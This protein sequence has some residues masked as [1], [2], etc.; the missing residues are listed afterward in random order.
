[1]LIIP[2]AS[3]SFISAGNNVIVPLK[4]VKGVCCLMSLTIQCVLA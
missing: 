4:L 2:Q 3:V 1:M